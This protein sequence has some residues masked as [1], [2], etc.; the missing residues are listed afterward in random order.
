M[1]A[2]Y[3]LLMAILPMVHGST[4]NLPLEEPR[5]YFYFYSNIKTAKI[6]LS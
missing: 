6:L 2:Y 5:N 4:I 3:I 1:P